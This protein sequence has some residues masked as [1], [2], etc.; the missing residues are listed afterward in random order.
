MDKMFKRVRAF[1]RGEVAVGPAEMV[2]PS[3]GAKS[4]SFPEPPPLIGTPEKQNL[5]K[6]C[7]YHGDRGHPP[8]QPAK[9]ELGKER[10]EGHKHDKEGRKPQ[11]KF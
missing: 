4:V 3:Q 2:R 6:F 5:N 7:D 9:W 10:C 1:T 11:E 8:K